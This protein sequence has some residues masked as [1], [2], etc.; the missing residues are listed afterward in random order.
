MGQAMMELHGFVKALADGKGEKILGCQI[1][2]P[3]AS[4]LI[5]EVAVAMKNGLTVQQLAKTVHAHPA[6]SEVVQRAFL[7]IR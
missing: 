6:L 4:T 5:H 1:L 7:A 3:D 2:G